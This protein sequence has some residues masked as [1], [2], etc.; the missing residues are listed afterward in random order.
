VVNPTR[1]DARE[2]PVPGRGT[3]HVPGHDTFR[4]ADEQPLVHQFALPSHGGMILLKP[5]RA[6]AMKR[7]DA[8]FVYTLLLLACVET[9]VARMS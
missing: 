3:A 5:E 6:S 9:A 7:H 4:R 2:I 1:P 8:L